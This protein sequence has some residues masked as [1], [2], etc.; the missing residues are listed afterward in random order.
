MKKIV[1][2][3]I[4]VLALFLFSSTLIPI[5]NA[6]GNDDKVSFP[7]DW[8]GKSKIVIPH[9][10]LVEVVYLRHADNSA[11][12]T[13]SPTV[14]EDGAWGGSSYYLNAYDIS[15][16]H[17][18]S[19]SVSYVVNA[20]YATKYGLRSQ[21]VV[22]AVQ[23]SFGAWNGV[24]P[25]LYKY[26][27]L[28]NVAKASLSKPDYKNVITWASISDRNVVAM[29]IMWYRTSD[30]ALLDCDI[31]MNTYYKWGI[32]RDGEGNAKTL[33]GAFDIRDIITHE[34]GHWTGLNDLYSGPYLPMTMFGYSAFGETYK[35][36]VEKG[37][38]DGVHQVY[39]GWT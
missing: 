11:A 18:T 28:N 34:A 5:A 23:G 1:F 12:V 31:V 37:D 17:W 15:G 14:V 29:S 33:N 2:I 16:Y 6:A 39:P 7:N 26:G 21:D 38:R 25:N 32:D 36:S 8:H 27:G 3:V 35:I 10:D 4:G 19:K 30:R 9:G 20:N 13:N 24:V 22:T